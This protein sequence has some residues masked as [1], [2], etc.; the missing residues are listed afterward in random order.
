MPCSRCYTSSAGIEIFFDCFYSVSRILTL[1]ARLAC[2][3]QRFDWSLRSGFRRASSY[4]IYR[5]IHSYRLRASSSYPYPS[6]AITMNVDLKVS[7]LS[8]LSCSFSLLTYLLRYWSWRYHC[9]FEV[10]YRNPPQNKRQEGEVECDIQLQ[11][12]VS[13]STHL[14]RLHFKQITAVGS[15]RLH[16]RPSCHTDCA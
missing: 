11:L 2:K 1:N 5:R 7:S 16:Y 9:Y 15:Y 4:W 8:P 3:A 14:I 10:G 12:H 6:K 13:Y